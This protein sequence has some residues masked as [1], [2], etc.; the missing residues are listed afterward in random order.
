MPKKDE[1]KAKSVPEHENT[2][3]NG[4]VR[5]GNGSGKETEHE[6]ENFDKIIDEII[7][8]SEKEKPIQAD[9]EEK[10]SLADHGRPDRCGSGNWT[11]GIS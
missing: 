11:L 1:I 9:D 7:D 4:S 2:L 8:K 10:G 5:S 3:V 6:T